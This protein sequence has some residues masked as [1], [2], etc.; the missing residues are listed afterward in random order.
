MPK[1]RN[2]PRESTDPSIMPMD[3]LMAA[4]ADAV[5]WHAAAVC[6]PLV[7]VAGTANAITA[8][9]DPPIT[10]YSDGLA[11][12][13]TPGADNTAP[14]TI[15]VSGVGAIDIVDPDGNALQAGG[16]KA[17]R[18]SL[19]KYDATLGDFILVG[20]SAAGGVTF[21]ER[22]TASKSLARPVGLV[23]DAVIRVRLWGAG[24][25]GGSTG[26]TGGGGGGGYAERDFR[27]GDLSWP[28]TVTIAAAP[29]AGSAGGNSTF[30]SYLTAYGGGRGRNAGSGGGG[31]GAGTL[32]SGSDS[33]GTSGASGGGLLGGSG[34]ASGTAGTDAVGGG[35][36]GGYGSPGSGG[37]GGAGV[38]GGGGGGGGSSGGAGAGGQSIYGGGGGGGS[39]SPSGAGGTS[40]YGG[41][42]GAGGAAGTA[43]AGGG[44][45]LAAGAR[46]EC[47]VYA[48][49]TPA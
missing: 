44:G 31:G 21:Y 15:N 4:V 28:V 40:K 2:V 18:R 12:W 19:L 25:G 13:F 1:R 34:G 14:V 33:S 20:G 46:G 10:S 17:G 47:I 3:D 37:V 35:G 30:G 26:N 16:L 45:A 11:F 5:D 9:C 38:L 8:T 48:V 27:V 49:G 24:G 22:I 32:A 29:A 43:P 36:G 7:S 6:L 23:D 41:A 39:G 42:G